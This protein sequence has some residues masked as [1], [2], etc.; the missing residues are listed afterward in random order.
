VKAFIQKTSASVFLLLGLWPILLAFYFTVKE[1]LIHYEMRQKLESH[2]LQTVIVPEQEVIWMEDHEI[3]VNNSMFDIRTKK[4]ENGVY[5]FT[6]MYDEDE[7]AMVMKQRKTSR[8]LSTEE[9]MVQQLLQCFRLLYTEP[10]NEQAIPVEFS[11]E[12]V[13]FI[14]IGHSQFIPP[15]LTP[16]PRWVS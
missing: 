1:A 12:A 7:T 11:G 10:E 6:G 14:R 13:S 3:W 16:P 9:R 8:S 2:E 5:T 15:I 4:L